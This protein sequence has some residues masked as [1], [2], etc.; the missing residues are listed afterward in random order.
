MQ[1]VQGYKSRGNF[2]FEKSDCE[3]WVGNSAFNGSVYATCDTAD[4][5]GPGMTVLEGSVT[6]YYH[7]TLTPDSDDACRVQDSFLD[8]DTYNYKAAFTQTFTDGNFTYNPEDVIQSSLLGWLDYGY[9]YG[10]SPQ[11]QSSKSFLTS[12]C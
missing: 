11:S 8:F 4:G 10:H 7:L 9:K 1:D 3:Q 5:I 2:S 12:A 6:S